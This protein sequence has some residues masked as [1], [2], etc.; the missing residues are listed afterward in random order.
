MEGDLVPIYSVLNVSTIFLKYNNEVPYSA[1]LLL[2]YNPSLL[3]TWGN[4]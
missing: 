2:I 4:L 3:G 1:I